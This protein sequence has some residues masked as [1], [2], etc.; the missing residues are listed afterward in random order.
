MSLIFKKWRIPDWERVGFKK[1]SEFPIGNA[2]DF[3]K[4]ANSRWGTRWI[5]KK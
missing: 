5:L 2:L 4:V 3:K 1:D